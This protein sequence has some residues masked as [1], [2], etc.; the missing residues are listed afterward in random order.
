ME[1]KA[2]GGTTYTMSEPGSTL[3]F[4][5]RKRGGMYTETTRAAT[6]HKN[7][8]HRGQGE[9]EVSLLSENTGIFNTVM[10]N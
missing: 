9:D 5:S 3:N 8:H 2:L 1:G 10:S 4:W 6:Y 7:K